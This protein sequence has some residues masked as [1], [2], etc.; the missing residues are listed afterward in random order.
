MSPAGTGGVLLVA[1]RASLVVDGG[2]RAAFPHL[3]GTQAM[4]AGQ[5]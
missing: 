4:K 5:G 1:E 2:M 3:G